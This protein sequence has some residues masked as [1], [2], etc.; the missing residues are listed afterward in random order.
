MF[1]HVAGRPNK[2]IKLAR[3]GADDLTGGR[4]VR[5]LSAM[6]FGEPRVGW[7]SRRSV[8]FPGL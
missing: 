4:R 2:R 1:E 7:L 5:S 6:R 8:L 3:R